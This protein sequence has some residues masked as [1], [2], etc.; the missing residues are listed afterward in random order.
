M[1]NKT[2]NIIFCIFILTTIHISACSAATA[3]FTMTSLPV[4][5]TATLEVA[6]E[7][8]TPSPTPTFQPT[9]TSSPTHTPTPEACSALNNM[10]P[11]GY[12]QL[13]NRLYRNS[14]NHFLEFED[15]K[16]PVLLYKGMEVRANLEIADALHKTLEA[17]QRGVPNLC[18]LKPFTVVAQQ[19]YL[20]D[21][22]N[23]RITPDFVEMLQRARLTFVIS[24]VEEHRSATSY[25]LG[26]LVVNPDK[27]VFE[28][29]G[30]RFEEVMGIT[31][32]KFKEVKCV[33]FMSVDDDE[34][35]FLSKLP[36]DC[37]F[38]ELKR[39]TGEKSIV[40]VWDSISAK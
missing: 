10:L 40:S 16:H 17:T 6:T 15:G 29:A 32:F 11:D 23:M 34:I 19:R 22:L 18:D 14:M 20:Y 8:P 35:D 4:T 3:T 36:G 37:T 27:V 7:T 39:A 31:D 9:G 21:N 28:N 24:Y 26:L 1:N 38:Y 25:V 12:S 5:D 30:V 33:G 13:L 2:T